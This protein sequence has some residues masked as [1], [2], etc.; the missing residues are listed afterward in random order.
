MMSAEEKLKK[1]ILR[2]YRSV[3]D[4]SNKCNIPYTTV[5]SILNKSI[6]R[7]SVTSIIQICDCLEISVDELVKGNIVQ[8]KKI[9][10]NSY[11]IN[12]IFDS[13]TISEQNEL[14][15]YAKYLKKNK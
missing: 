5:V 8:N 9:Q 2:N 15:T 3:M 14:I 11:V 4:F 7:A 6:N 13:M 1:Y 10:N 12:E